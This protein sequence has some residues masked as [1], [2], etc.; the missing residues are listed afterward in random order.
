MTTLKD[1]FRRTAFVVLGLM[2][3]GGLGQAHL[4]DDTDLSAQLAAMTGTKLMPSD[5]QKRLHDLERLLQTAGYRPVRTRV[6]DDRTAI[7]SWYNPQ[8][9]MTTLAFWSLKTAENSFSAGQYAGQLPWT[10][11]V[12]D[13]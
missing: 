8:T 10:Q 11:V 7:A 13:R 6:F 5:C 1:G 3:L 12:A 4:L 2:T 9:S